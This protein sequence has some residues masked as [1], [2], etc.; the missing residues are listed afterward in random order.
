[1]NKIAISLIALSLMA[2]GAFASQRNNDEPAGRAFL[3]NTDI[4]TSNAA[5][6]SSASSALAVADQEFGGSAFEL[7]T[8]RATI[9]QNGDDN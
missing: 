4:Y 6:E 7:L 3:G 8:K 2:S 5:D 9:R 1:M